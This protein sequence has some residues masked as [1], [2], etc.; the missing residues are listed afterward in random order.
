MRKLL[1]VTFL[2]TGLVISLVGS[3]IM[4]AEEMQD[5]EWGAPVNGLRCSITSDKKSYFYGETTD[6]GIEVTLQNVSGALLTISSYPYNYF[7]SVTVEGRGEHEWN[8]FPLPRGRRRRENREDYHEL[9]P[10]QK[11][12][13]PVAGVS[14]TRARCGRNLQDNLEKSF[15]VTEDVLPIVVAKEADRKEIPVRLSVMYRKSKP[16]EIDYPAVWIGEVESNKVTVKFR[17]KTK[18][19]L[20]AKVSELIERIGNWETTWQEK[21]SARQEIIHLGRPAIEPLREFLKRP[22]KFTYDPSNPGN[23]RTFQP[24][25]HSVI[26]DCFCEIGGDVEPLLSLLQAKPGKTRTDQELGRLRLSRVA[27]HLGHMGDPKKVVGPLI[28]ALEEYP[29]CTNIYSAL[30]RIS[31]QAGIRGTKDKN[32]LELLVRG[33]KSHSS[34]IIANSAW[35]FGVVTDKSFGYDFHAPAKERREAIKKMITWWEQNK[36]SLGKGK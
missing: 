2:M 3:S 18:A 34:V 14:L 26:A 28:K 35:L 33:L 1:I 36:D 6:V 7:V 12:S 21:T 16:P 13:L 22:D 30:L 27:H 17:S 8:L 32:L 25:L 20:K 15:G 9:T 5:R 29:D 31:S 24:T 11:F 4:G 23:L 19:E 10:G